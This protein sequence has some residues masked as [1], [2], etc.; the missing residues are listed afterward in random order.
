MGVSL[1]ELLL[2]EQIA[3]LRI[4]L[5]QLK[6]KNAKKLRDTYDEIVSELLPKRYEAVRIV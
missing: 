1:T 4:K 2:R 3:L 6:K 5:K